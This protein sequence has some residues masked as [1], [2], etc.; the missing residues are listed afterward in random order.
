VSKIPITTLFQKYLNNQINSEELQDLLRYFEHSD[1]GDDLT[2]LIK[3]ELDRADTQPDELSKAIADRAAQRIIA[4]TRPP[5]TVSGVSRRWTSGYW[6]R[7]AAAVLVVVTGSIYFFLKSTGGLQVPVAQ[8]AD[9]APGSNQATLTLPD[10]RTI[11]LDTA[12][13]GIVVANGIKY[14]DGNKLIDN[15]QLAMDNGGKPQG[16]SAAINY[17]LSTPKGGT[18]RVTLPDG[19]RVWLNAASALR[20]PAQFTGNTREVE[21]DGEGY[22]EVAKDA[23]RP[24][25]VKSNGQVVRVLGTVFNI[26]A[27]P[28]EAQVMTTLVEGAV[29]VGSNT[30]VA[31]ASL[32]F[33]TLKPGQ[34]AAFKGG[35]IQVITVDASDYVAWKD[36]R[37]VFYN[38]PLP[39]VIKKLER[40]YDV[41]FEHQ[42]L[43]AGIEFWGSL[44][45]N[46]ML[47]EIL[48]VI[49]LNTP[50]TF[51]RKG[52]RIIVNEK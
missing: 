17:Q 47:S 19:T 30:A 33:V 5:R 52:R 21:L 6:V 26:N 11:D 32:A 36:G 8:L 39:L 22:F 38:E 45:R 46:V 29:A 34:Q 40:W 4:R 27:Y 41:S 18:Y 51:E 1:V 10:G 37:F 2:P 3:Q 42:E 28:D 49:E 44:S 13:G 35:H 43:A 15:G 25:L 23:H 31:R 9:I 48:E 20:Y 16:G 24:F 14:V 7:V 12:Q 50:L